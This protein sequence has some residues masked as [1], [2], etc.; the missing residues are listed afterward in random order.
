MKSKLSKIRR[1]TKDFKRVLNKLIL[2][3]PREEV[4]TICLPTQTYL[5]F[6]YINEAFHGSEEV[7]SKHYISLICLYDGKVNSHAP[8]KEHDLDI[9]CSSLDLRNIP[10]RMF[11]ERW[12]IVHVCKVQRIINNSWHY[13]N[14]RSNVTKSKEIL[15]RDTN[16]NKR[17][18]MIFYFQN[19][20]S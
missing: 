10:I 13:R 14:N 15:F 11:M 4:R 1:V 16:S 8:F 9:F 5:S 6:T 19:L 7:P 3:L 2:V 17:F 20:L 18:P 12:K